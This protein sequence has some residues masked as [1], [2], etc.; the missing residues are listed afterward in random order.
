MVHHRDQLGFHTVKVLFV[1]IGLVAGVQG[2]PAL[3]ADVSWNSG[4]A[5]VLLRAVACRVL[6]PRSP[7]A[8]WGRY[9][10]SWNSAVVGV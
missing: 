1:R 4:A 10:V 5:F 2:L 9:N 6:C 3:I 7:R 8:G